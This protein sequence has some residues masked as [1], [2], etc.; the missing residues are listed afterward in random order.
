M[1]AACWEAWKKFIA[2]SKW[3]RKAEFKAYH[4]FTGKLEQYYINKWLD[5]VDVTRKGKVL[6]KQREHKT[7]WQIWSN[8]KWIHRAYFIVGQFRRETLLMH[9]M[10]G[11]KRY[12]KEHK[13]ERIMLALAQNHF[14]SG[15]ARSYFERWDRHCRDGKRYKRDLLKAMGYVVSINLRAFA[16]KRSSLFYLP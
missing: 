4:H 13:S 14:S 10:A 6:A 1:R 3:N 5:Y 12:Y 9:S 8:W 7:V 11:W 15:T 2:L 16:Q